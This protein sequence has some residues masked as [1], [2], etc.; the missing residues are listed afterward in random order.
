MITTRD[1][2][3]ISVASA[4][5]LTYAP[6]SAYGTWQGSESPILESDAFHN[7]FTSISNQLQALERCPD[8]HEVDEAEGEEQTKMEEV[9]ETKSELPLSSTS[10]RSLLR[11][12][13]KLVSHEILNC[14][15][16]P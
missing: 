16:N 6:P 12:Y 11:E 1:E 10:V 3:M 4:M 13:S 5:S 9:T 8:L 14:E 15:E 2:D 7:D